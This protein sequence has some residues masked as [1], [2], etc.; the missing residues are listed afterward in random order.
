MH[1]DRWLF[2]AAFGAH[3]ALSCTTMNATKIHLFHSFSAQRPNWPRLLCLPPSPAPP[4]LPES[5]HARRLS[6]R[7]GRTGQ[8]QSPR[9]TDPS[10][11]LVYDGRGTF[12]SQRKSVTSWQNLDTKLGQLKVTIVTADWSMLV[13]FPGLVQDTLFINANSSQVLQLLSATNSLVLTSSVRL[14]WAEHTLW[15]AVCTQL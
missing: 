1:E 3:A 7:T 5:N 2:P 9:P 13:P 14:H 11:V 8:R 10:D 4:W 15:K 6:P 12:E